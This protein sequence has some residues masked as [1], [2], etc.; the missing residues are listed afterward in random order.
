MG[1]N[2]SIIRLHP[3]VNIVSVTILVTD[4]RDGLLRGILRP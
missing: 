3:V 4:V 1:A 2:E